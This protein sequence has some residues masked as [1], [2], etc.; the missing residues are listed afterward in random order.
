MQNKENN[1]MFVNEEATGLEEMVDMML[2]KTADEV[3]AYHEALVRELHGHPDGDSYPTKA[4][5]EK[6]RKKNA[7]SWT[8]DEHK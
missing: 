2:V 1:S 4:K 5:K 8:I 6:T 3:K 7:N